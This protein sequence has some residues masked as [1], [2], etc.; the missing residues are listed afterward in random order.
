M[1][2][3]PNESYLFQQLTRATK[4]PGKPLRVVL[5]ERRREIVAVAVVLL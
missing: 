3:G 1:L 4:F 2:L 5:L